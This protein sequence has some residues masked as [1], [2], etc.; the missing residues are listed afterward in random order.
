MVNGFDWGS[1]VTKPLLLHQ[2]NACVA[3]LLLHQSRVWTLWSA[4][5]ALFYSNMAARLLLLQQVTCGGQPLGANF[6]DA[7]RCVFTSVQLHE[8]RRWGWCCCCR[9]RWQ[10]RHSE[11]Y[12]GYY[13]QWTWSP[14][15]AMWQLMAGCVYWHRFGRHGWRTSTYL[16]ET[17]GR[18]STCVPAKATWSLRWSDTK[19]PV[20]MAARR[21]PHK[22]W[23]TGWQPTSCLTTEICV[24]RKGKKILHTDLG[25]RTEKK[26]ICPAK[27]CY[28]PLA[29]CYSSVP[30][31]ISHAIALFLLYRC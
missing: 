13:K 5:H 29:N 28:L 31:P 22:T 3:N 11:V 12:S 16:T 20:L 7:A 6:H 1:Q 26:T 19:P 27:L 10:L 18:D 25:E 17:P 14:V 23:R 4:W 9:R 30:P 24:L 8:R 15:Q 2:S 21:A